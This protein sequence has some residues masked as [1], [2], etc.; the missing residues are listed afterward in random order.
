MTRPLRIGHVLTNLHDGGIER[1][2]FELCTGLDRDRFESCVYALIRD[3]PWIDR[4]R[5]AGI[6]VRTY[7]AINRISPRAFPRNAK[8]MLQLAADL[9]DDQIDIGQAHDFFPGVLGRCAMAMAG[10][11]HRIA[12][13]HNTYTW[14]GRPHGFL[15][16]LLALGSDR[17]VGVSQAC[18]EDSRRRDRI[19]ESKYRVIYNGVDERAYHPAFECRT[20]LRQELGWPESA[21]IIGNIGTVSERKRQAD[22]VEAF[23][24]LI[25]QHPDLRLLLIGS[26]RSH[27]AE[28]AQDLEKRLARPELQGRWAWLSDRHDVERL[29]AGCDLFCMPSRVEGFSVALVEALMTGLPVVLSDIPSFLETVNDGNDGTIFP[30]GDVNALAERLEQLLADSLLRTRLGAAGRQSALAKF[31]N[32]NMI[33]CWSHLYSELAAV[34][35]SQTSAP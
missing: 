27:E 12:T 28:V 4:F 14:L 11:P 2:V 13:L 30:L 26:R 15:N 10:T 23:A 1:V 19:P 6:S 5:E 16:R 17:I 20:A 31:S 33:R 32:A 35:F 8:V 29:L 34:P 25:P 7:H 24:R 22:L 21:T 18:V 3:N 9:R